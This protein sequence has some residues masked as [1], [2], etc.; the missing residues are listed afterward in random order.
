MGKVAKMG[1]NEDGLLKRTR[2]K[3]RSHGHWEGNRS[4]IPK[5]D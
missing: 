3:A 1:G 2:R 4:G 5:H